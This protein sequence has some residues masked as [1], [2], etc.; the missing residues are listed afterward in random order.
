MR[1]TKNYDP[2]NERL[3][4]NITLSRDFFALIYVSMGKV[5]GSVNDDVNVFHAPSI[6]C[7]SNRDQVSELRLHKNTRVSIVYFDTVFLTKDMSMD[8]L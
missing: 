3:E 2:F 5:Y 6:I 4:R 1:S 8:T 7:L